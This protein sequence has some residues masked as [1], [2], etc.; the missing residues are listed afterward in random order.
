MDTET[1]AGRKT[2]DDLPELAD[3][4]A[5][6]SLWFDDAKAAEPAD[7]NAMALATATPDGR[8]SVRIVLLKGLDGEGAEPRGFV[9]F[10]NLDSRKG[11][12]LRSNPHAALCFHWKSLTRQVRVEGPILPVSPAEA[13]AYYATRPRGS[14]IGAW[15]SDQSRPLADKAELVARV[16]EYEARFGDGDIPRPPHWSGF[17]LVPS[18]I[19]FW[20]D[21]PFRLHDRLVYH[22]EAG[23]PAR[24]RTERLYP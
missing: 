20:H 15:A 12:E 9:F 13:D 4:F 14:R 11:G 3:P 23:T 18:R 6:F 24:W 8:P 19:E 21:R 5:L 2:G 16:V 22:R 10:T 17:R 1:F 7:P